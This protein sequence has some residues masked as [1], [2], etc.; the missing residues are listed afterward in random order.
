MEYIQVLYNTG[1]FV[2]I[3]GNQP[4]ILI[5]DRGYRGEKDFGNTQFLILKD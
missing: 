4:D 2:G 5:A 3:T 1:S